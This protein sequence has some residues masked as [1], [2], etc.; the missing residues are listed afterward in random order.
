[1]FTFREVSRKNKDKKKKSKSQEEESSD[2][3]D[4]FGNDSDMEEGGSDV[5]D[6]ADDDGFKMVND[7]FDEEGFGASDEEF[8]GEVS[9]LNFKIDEDDFNDEE[10]TESLDIFKTM[11]ETHTSL[12]T[13]YIWQKVYRDSEPQCIVGR[14]MGQFAMRCMLS[15][16]TRARMAYMFVWVQ[17]GHLLIFCYSR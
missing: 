2:D 13:I 8:E 11:F 9:E 14:R 3:E 15:S 16:T 12:H 7:E 6:D 5:D 17:Q 4:D 1:M 10:F